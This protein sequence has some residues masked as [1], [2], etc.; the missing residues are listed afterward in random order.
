VGLKRHLRTITAAGSLSLTLCAGAAI[1]AP[2]AAHAAG[3]SQY[4][5]DGLGNEYREVTILTTPITLAVE[6]GS[7]GSL[8]NPNVG[9]CYATSPEGTTSPQTAGGSF[10]VAGNPY[11]SN[12]TIGVGSTS[13]SNSAEQVNGGANATPTYS[14]T[15]GPAGSTGDVISVTIPFTVCLGPCTGTGTG[16]N[17]TGVLVGQLVPVAQPGIGVG[18]TLQSLDVFV[19]GTVVFHEAPTTLAG[20]YVNPFGAVEESLDISQG[21]PCTGIACVPQGYVGTTGANYAGISILGVPVNVGGPLTKQCV[22]WNPSTN[23]CP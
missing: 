15:P 22:Y 20:A 16:L 3:T 8:L 14:I 10:A 12:P 4:C 19:N 1:G 6:I 2:L 5:N 11:G 7:G 9:I 13:D 23:R 18:Y 21:G 17:P